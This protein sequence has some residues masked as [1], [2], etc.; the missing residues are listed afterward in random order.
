MGKNHTR[1][2]VSLEPWCTID[3]PGEL[4]SMEK[5]LM[6]EG[7]RQG[8]ELRGID[9]G[10]EVLQVFVDPLECQLGESGEENACERR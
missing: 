10:N 3:E 9:L 4:W 8:L 6:E 1:F 7:Y 5:E 2:I